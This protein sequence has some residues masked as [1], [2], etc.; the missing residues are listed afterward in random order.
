MDWK[1]MR[2]WQIQPVRDVLIVGL[3]VGLVYL[4]YLASVVTVPILLALLLA[5]LFEPLVAWLCRKGVLSRRGSALS[6]IFIAALVIVVPAVLGGTFAIVQGVRFT[7]DTVRNIDLLTKSVEKSDDEVLR[8]RITSEGWGRLRDFLVKENE[9]RKAIAS[10]IE[11]HDI[12]GAGAFQSALVWLRN[13][14]QEI[15]KQAVLTGAGAFTLAAHALQSIVYLVFTAA[16]TAFFFY[17]FSTG[18][19]RV[20]AFWESLIPEKRKWRVIELVQQMDAVIAGFVRG[21]VIICAIIGV[22]ATIAYWMAGAP[23]PLVLG[24]VV[25][26]LF[27]VPY[28]HALMVPVVIVA[29][30]IDP[31]GVAW[32]STWWWILLGPVVV[33]MSCQLLD[34]YVLTPTIQGNATGMD[35]PTIVFASFAGGALMGVYGL[36]IA[37]PLAACIKILLRELF[38]PRFKAWAEGRAKDFL[39]LDDKR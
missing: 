29:M 39:P 8:S 32:Q 9:K 23:A 11:G 20:L 3:I 21:R 28:V 26:A 31:S 5:Y 27:I 37:I 22:W 6:I 25:G 14:S 17:F 34:D 24:P 36:L 16:L 33:Y 30:A 35:T 18:W 7:E 2:L 15:G 12:G 38:W 19:G 4:G 13:N 10:G 1:S